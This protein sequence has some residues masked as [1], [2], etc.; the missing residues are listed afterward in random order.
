MVQLIVCKP[1][2]PYGGTIQKNPPTEI[3]APVISAAVHSNFV[4]STAQA[5]VF[6]L[7]HQLF[8]FRQYGVKCPRVYALSHTGVYG[9][10]WRRPTH[11][12][13]WNLING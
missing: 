5:D 7:Q 2:T 9:A 11:S 3:T 6:P 10:W 4:E 1:K 12:R 8:Q 13:P